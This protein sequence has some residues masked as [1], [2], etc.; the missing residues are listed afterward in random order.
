MSNVFCNFIILH[1]FSMEH[2]PCLCTTTTELN[3]NGPK[4]PKSFYSSKQMFIFAFFSTSFALSCR[5]IPQMHIPP[6]PSPDRGHPPNRNTVHP[7]MFVQIAHIPAR[8][9]PRTPGDDLPPL[10]A[11]RKYTN[12]APDRLYIY[13]IEGR[14]RSGRLSVSGRI[15]FIVGGDALIAPA[16]ERRSLLLFSADTE[17]A[18]EGIGPYGKLSDSLSPPG[19]LYIR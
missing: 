1:N 13:I 8:P 17:R 16:V 6:L 12:T 10:P 5:C 2:F 4:D 9:P 3:N 7:S 15:L 19:L 14:P 18:D 11:C